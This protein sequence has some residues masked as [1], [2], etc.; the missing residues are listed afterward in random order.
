MSA[1]RFIATGIELKSCLLIRR[2]LFLFPTQNCLHW[3]ASLDLDSHL[4]N[5]LTYWNALAFAAFRYY[6]NS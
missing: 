3:E 6:P 5:L 2:I 4:T 1:C